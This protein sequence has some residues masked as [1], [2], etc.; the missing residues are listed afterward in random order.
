MSVLYPIYGLTGLGMGIV[1]GAILHL[2]VNLYGLR[3]VPER[4][5]S[6]FNFSFAHVRDIAVVAGPR[7]V[8]LGVQQLRLLTFATAGSLLPA[9][10][11]SVYNLS[12]NL[13]WIP[14]SIIVMSYLVTIY[15]KLSIIDNK[16]DLSDFVS[17]VMNYFIFILMPIICF[18]FVLRAYIVRIAYGS[19]VFD[20]QSTR[21]IAAT[22]AVFLFVLIFDAIRKL[23]SRVL[24]ARG[25]V[26][27]QLLIE[28]VLLLVQSLI[29]IFAF[30]YII[31]I[32]SPFLSSLL[33]I[34]QSSTD[35]IG[36]ALIFL[37]LAIVELCVLYLFV[38]RHVDI[39]ISQ[40]FF[41][42]VFASLG[43]GLVAY[44]GLNIFEDWNK[45]NETTLGL[46]LQSGLAFFM[47]VAVWYVVLKIFKNSEIVLLEDA[48]KKKIWRNKI[49]AVKENVEAVE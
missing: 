29:F 18:G 13:Y 25:V 23:F 5:W 17:N 31:N 4:I 38:R 7:S 20:W 11:I 35:I 3:R 19:G 34:S 15:P 40:S 48:V 49:E 30:R 6:G 27:A 45:I 24:F 39:K 33:N 28:L 37:I 22:F 1:V 12:Y 44:L 36:L 9:G 42:T 8:T 43:G 32:S 21:L 14:V 41:H 10:A 47:G 26:Y 46:M 16:K 2:S